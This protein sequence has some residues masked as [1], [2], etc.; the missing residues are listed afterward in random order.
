MTKHLLPSDTSFRFNRILVKS[1]SHVRNYVQCVNI[2][3]S[4]FDLENLRIKNFHEICTRQADALR[5]GR[6]FR[7][8]SDS[9]RWT[10]FFYWL[11]LLIATCSRA[12]TCPGKYL[13]LRRIRWQQLGIL[14]SEE[15]CYRSPV[16]VRVPDRRIQ[17]T[18]NAA[19][20]EKRGN[21]HLEDLE[22]DGGSKFWCILRRQVVKVIHES[23][24]IRIFIACLV[25]VLEALKRRLL[26]L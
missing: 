13:D 20:M 17:W 1:K 12:T 18:G 25:L 23:N 8:S 3:F 15:S 2:D 4:Q 5:K 24:C 11:T 10:L 14:H 21:L 9:L 26:L 6:L 16:S 22:G 7:I 19:R